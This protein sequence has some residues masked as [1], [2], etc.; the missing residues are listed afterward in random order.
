M[1]YHIDS[2]RFKRKTHQSKPWANKEIDLIKTT[3]GTIRI[4]DTKGDK[5]PILIIPDGPNIIEHH[6]E[7]IEDLRTDFRMICFDLPGFG[8]SFH[9]GQ[10]DY[11]FAKTNHL[12]QEILVA[13]GL[14]KINL[15]M[16]CA[17]GFYGL[18]FAKKYPEKVNH[19]I[20]LQ[21]PALGE[22]QK[23]TNRIVPSLLKTP[24]F[25]QLAMPFMEKKFAK[26]WYEYALP[27]GTDRKPYQKIALERIQQGACFCL[28]S[29]SQGLGKEMNTD[30]KIDTT[31][32]LTLL[33]GNKDFSHK[34]TDFQSIKEY[35]SGAK[36]IEFDSFGHFPDLEAPEKYRTILKE[37]LL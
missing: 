33:Y 18:A 19:L 24:V 11:S 4:L 15:A 29:L 14:K 17:N 5:T 16:P 8:F 9:N 28:C 32:P 10:Y 35:H 21:T 34:G 37:E 3:L 27:K 23:W 20:L 22:M 7:N 31:I 30:L 1:R 2:M 13:L 25:G 26:V 12:I 36:L 6:L